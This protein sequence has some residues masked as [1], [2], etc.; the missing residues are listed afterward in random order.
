MEEIQ[1][2]KTLAIILMITMMII[3]TAC[4]QQKGEQGSTET[5]STTVETTVNEST[6]TDTS[7]DETGTSEED[8]QLERPSVNMEALSKIEADDNFDVKISGVELI[9]QYFLNPDLPPRA[10]SGAGDDG[11]KVTI[12]NNTNQMIT[13]VKA[14]LI[15]YRADGSAQVLPIGRSTAAQ[16]A[17]DFYIQKL[18]VST[19][20][21]TGEKTEN[22]SETYIGDVLGVKYIVASYTAGGKEVKNPSADEWY[23]SVFN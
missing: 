2:K 13:G 16:S 21:E 23:N 3:L 4:G 5:I 1:L 15:G 20:V 8:D 7:E 17:Q 12:E 19:E 22:V 14:Y 10:R 6:A 9:P 18:E 11:L